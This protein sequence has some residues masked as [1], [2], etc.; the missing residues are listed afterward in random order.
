MSSAATTPQ[1][2]FPEFS[3]EW[4][5]KNLGEVANFFDGK[6]VPIESGNRQQMQGKYPYYGAS[7]VIDYINSYIFD[8]EYVLLGEDGAN[9]ILRSTPLA[10][11]VKGKFWLNNHAHIMQSHGSNLFLATSLERLKYDKYNTGTI[12]PKLNS[13]VVKKIKI[14]IPTNKEQEKI[15]EFLTAVDEKIGTLEQ[16]VENIETYKRGMMQ[17]IFSQKIRF[18]HSDGSQYPQWQT[19]KLGELGSFYR[20]LTYDKS[21]VKEKGNLVLRSGNI[22]EGKLVLNRDLQFVNEPVHF[23]QVLQ[24]GDI[25]ICMANGSRNLVGKSGV[26]DGSYDGTITVGAFCSVYR[27]KNILTI[28]LLQSWQYLKYLDMLLAGTNINN[29]KNS[30]LGEL[31]FEIPVDREEQKKV[32]DFL[33]GLDSKIIITREKLEKTKEFKKGILQRMFV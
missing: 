28:Y 18:T 13:E 17:K 27:S 7:G 16:K 32:A 24:E 31:K 29:L 3:D 10:F 1:L 6:R 21:N 33:S 4:Q 20:G 11:V 9:I 30:D 14:S 23:T 2:R 15:A 19:K 5:V 22:Q 12:Q 8:G 26:Y 25:A